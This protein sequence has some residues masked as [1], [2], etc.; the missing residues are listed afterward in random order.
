MIDE[1]YVSRLFS[2]EKEVVVITGG[3]GKL[4]THMTEVLV[5]AGARVASLDV[6]DTPNETLQ[7][8]AEQYPLRFLKADV[9][10]EQDV[11]KAIQGL[12]ATWGVPTI[13]INNAGWKASPNDPQGAGKPFEE[14]SM[15]LWDTV[16]KINLKSAAVCSKVVGKRMVEKGSGVIVG[17]S[18][19]YSLNSPDHGIYQ[20]KVDDGKERFVKDAS[21]GASKAGMNA[22]MRDLAVQ[23]GPHGIRSLAVA[24]GGVENPKSD[25]RFKDAYVKHVPLGRMARPDEYAGLILFLVSPAASYITGTTI[26]ADGGWGAL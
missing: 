26:V 22:L 23:W 25:Q 12:E 18:S 7:R 9:T 24:F 5:K 2:L 13:L 6:V 15:E 3:L 20:Y 8:L 10:N 11:E 16:I 14:Y 17:I 4:A 1:R 19:H 21:Y